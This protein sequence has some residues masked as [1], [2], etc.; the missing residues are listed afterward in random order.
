MA[1]P[2]QVVAMAAMTS[3][4]LW[5]SYRVWTAVQTGAANVHNDCVRRRMRPWYYWTAVV[6]QAGFAVACFLAVAQRFLR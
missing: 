3:L 2:L 5:L 1:L 4:G 6:V